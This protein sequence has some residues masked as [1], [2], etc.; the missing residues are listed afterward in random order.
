MKWCDDERIFCQVQL[1]KS[2]V[3]WMSIEIFACGRWRKCIRL[4]AAELC[5]V[6]LGQYRTKVMRAGEMNFCQIVLA[7]FAGVAALR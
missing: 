4:R 7:E 3:D 2:K 6:T 5:G 1:Q